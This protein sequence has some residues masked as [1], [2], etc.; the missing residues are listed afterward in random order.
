[1]KTLDQIINERR[2]VRKYLNKRVED[3]DISAVLEAAR[4]AP[5]ACNAQPWRF[6]NVKDK[7][8]KNRLATDALGGVVPNRWARTAPVIIVACSDLNMVTHSFGEYFQGVKYH[9]I[10]MGI[11]LEHIVLKATEI[12]LG[13]CY[14]GWF[15]GKEIKRILKLPSSWEVEC[16]LAL[17]HAEKTPEASSRKKLSEI[18]RVH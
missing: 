9:L 7:E 6:V 17:G 1:M 18:S 13:T 2:S 4:L 15:K 16:L 5:S 10:D 11:A 14:M 12:G 8:L 3:E